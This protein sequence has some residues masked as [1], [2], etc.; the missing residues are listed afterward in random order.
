MYKIE[1]FLSSGSY[2]VYLFIKILFKKI[3][4]I[5]KNLW[6]ESSFHKFFEEEKSY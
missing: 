1:S 4:E 3:T 5:S 6:E 2:V